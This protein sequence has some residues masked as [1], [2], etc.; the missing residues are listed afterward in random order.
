LSVYGVPNVK[1]GFIVSASLAYGDDYFPSYA[2]NSYCASGNG[3]EGEWVTDNVWNNFWIQVECVDLVR[4]WKVALIGRILTE[5][6]T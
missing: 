5:K 2:F 3:H 1:T 6:D 4:V